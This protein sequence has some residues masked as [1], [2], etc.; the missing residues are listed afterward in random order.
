MKLDVSETLDHLE[1]FKTL[2]NFKNFVILSEFEGLKELPQ[3]S[4]V[5]ENFKMANISTI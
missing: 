2:G 3:N 1:M 4:K 5:S